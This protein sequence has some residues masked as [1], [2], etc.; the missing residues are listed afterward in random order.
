MTDDAGRDRLEPVV[1]ALYGCALAS[2]LTTFKQDALH[3][4][5]AVLPFDSAVWGSGIHSSNTMLSLTLLDQPTEMLLEYAAHW[6]D[7]DFCRNAAVAHPGRAFSNGLVQPL[8]QYRATPVYRDFSSRWRIEDTLTIVQPN[9]GLDLAEIVCLFRQ[10]STAMFTAADALML[11]RLAPHLARAWSHAQIAHHNWFGTQGAPTG[12]DVGS[13]GVVAPDG[14]LKAAGDDLLVRLRRIAPGWAGPRLPPA[15]EELTQGVRKHI[16]IAGIRFQAHAAGQ[17]VLIASAPERSNATL[18]AAEL[19]AARLYVAGLTKSEVAARLG[20]SPS[21]IRNQL[22]SAYAKL[23]CHTKLE[24]LRMLDRNL[25][26]TAGIYQ[27]PA[28]LGSEMT[29]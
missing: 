5:K 1:G 26:P 14:V 22:A 20:V 15:L 13:Y 28:R 24:L 29:G 12:S 25:G 11:E 27:A 7:S 16:R 4:I 18:T 17:D 10:D 23:G 8:E 2:P 21:T 9:S 6:Q 3:L 19:S